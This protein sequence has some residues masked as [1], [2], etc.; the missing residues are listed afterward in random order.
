MDEVGR[1]GKPH[2]DMQDVRIGSEVR[3]HRLRAGLSQARLGKALGVSSQQVQKYERGADRISANRL[4]RIA[5]VV[6][7]SVA[8]LYAVMEDEPFAEATPSATA[9]DGQDTRL[10]RALAR[11]ED[12]VV[13]QRLVFLVESLVP[14][15][16]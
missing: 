5:A 7:V 16:A 11:I 2:A 13:R 1:V 9:L 15:A 4:R 14:R 6:G 3:M 10:M 8:H 12:P